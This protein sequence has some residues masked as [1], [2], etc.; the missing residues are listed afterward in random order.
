[1]RRLALLPALLGVALACAGS[2]KITS[3]DIVET[4]PWDVPETTEYRVLDDDDDEVGTLTLS[5][6]ETDGGMLLFRQY[7]DFPEKG[8]INEAAVIAEP[9]EMQPSAA[10]FR[11]EGPEGDLNCEA[12]YT[13]GHVSVHRVGE[14]GERTDERAVPDIVYDSWGDLFLWRT[15]QF[16]EGNEHKYADVLSCTLDRTQTLGVTIKV[17]EIEEVEVPAGTFE[18]WRIEIDSGGETQKAWYGTDARRPLIK[19]DNGR[20]TFEL[21][22]LD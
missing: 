11:I 21:T 6:E 17:K 18:A 19:Y 5:I 13:P 8:F 20:E 1:M 12:E 10:S 4:I 7:F 14:D 16:G 3:A 15:I 9:E 2:E 22:S